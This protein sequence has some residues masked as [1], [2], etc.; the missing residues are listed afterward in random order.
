[1]RGLSY[2]RLRRARWRLLREYSSAGVTDVVFIGFMNLAG[3]GAWFCTTSDSQ[4][5]LLLKRLPELDA[6]VIS[7][8]G[9]VGFR[10]GNVARSGA[11]V[12]SQETVDRD[13]ESN[14]RYAV[15]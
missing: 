3:V 10:G 11:T 4:G 14:W 7:V 15:K 8:L 1:M 5:D 12:E 6:R 13:Y 9:E 2:F